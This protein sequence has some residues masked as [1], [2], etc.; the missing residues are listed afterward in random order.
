[1]GA[2]QTVTTAAPL[3][4]RMTTPLPLVREQPKNSAGTVTAWKKVVSYDLAFLLL[5]GAVSLI[6]SSL[7]F[8]RTL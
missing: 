3:L 1:M 5:F 7:L 8:K 4:R 2:V 6:A